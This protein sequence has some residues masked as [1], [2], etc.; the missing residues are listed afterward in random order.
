MHFTKWIGVCSTFLLLL[1]LS[2]TSERANAQVNINQGFEVGTTLP[3]G[4]VGTSWSSTTTLPCT[5]LRSVRANLWSSGQQRNIAPPAWLSNGNDVD[6]SFDYKVINFSAPNAA[7]PPGWGEFRLEY[8]V[9]GGTTYSTY[10]TINDGNHVQS[11]SCATVNQ[12]IPGSLVPS[13]SNV[14]VRFFGQWVTGDY[15]VY[16]D[17]VVIFQEATTPPNCDAALTTP[18][19]ASMSAAINGTLI[20]S[21]ATGSPSGYNVIATQVT[22]GP[23]EIYN[24]NL[25]VVTTTNIGVLQYS[26]AYEI[27]IIPYNQFGNG[28]GCT[29]Y[30]FTTVDPPPPGNVCGIPLTVNGLPFSATDNTGSYGDD[31]STT[32]KPL[33]AVVYPALST[34]TGSGSYLNGDDVVYAYTPQTDQ[35]L[36]ITLTGHGT[37]VG[38]WVFTGCPF[39]TTLAYHTT[40]DALGRAINNLPLSAGETYYIVIS[41]FPTPQSTAYTLNMEEVLF[42]CPELSANIGDACDDGFAT[43]YADTVL[44]DCSCVGTPYDCQDL[45]ANIGSSCDDDNPATFNDLVQEDC[46][47]AGTP[48]QTNDT[49]CDA[50]IIECGDSVSGTTQG[51]TADV[52]GTCGTSDGTAGGVWYV[53]VPTS[54]ANITASL[55]GGGT[56]YDSKIRVF[57]GACDSLVCVGGNDDFCGLQSELNFVASSGTTY[58]ILVHGFSAASGPYTLSVTCDIIYDCPELQANIG[59][60]CDDNDV[61]TGDDTVLEDC[62]CAGTPLPNDAPCLAD[63]ISCGDTVTGTTVGAAGD[64][65]PFC[66]TSNGTG[67]GLWYA[68]TPTAPGLVTASLCGSA[69]DTKLRVFE[70]TCDTLVCVAGNDDACGL[71]SEI[72]FGAVAGTTYYILVHGFSGGQG[73]FNLEVTCVLYDCPEILANIGDACDDGIAGTFGDSIAEDCSCVG[74]PYDCQELLANIGSSCNDENADTFN[75]LVQADCTCAGTPAQTNDTACEAESI[76]CGATVSGTTQGTTADVLGFC[77]TSDGTGGGVWYALDATTNANI[78]ASLCGGGT[79]YDSKIRVFEGSCDALVCVGG[80]DDAC[81][82][83][84]EIAFAASAGTT[85][86]ILVHG[87]NTA[88]GAYSLAVTCATSFDCPEIQA[89]IGDACDDADPT[90][91]N[92]AVQADCSCAGTPIVIDCVADPGCLADVNSAAYA[93]VISLDPFCCNAD[94]DS[95][96]QNA[97]QAQGGL[98]NPAPECAFDCP[99]LLA[100]IGDACDDADPNTENDAVQA[101]CSCAGTPIVV[102]CVADP[103][104][105]ADVNSAAY[106][107][108]IAADPF[109]CDN[110]WDSLC[111]SAYAAEGGLPSQDPACFDCPELLAN[112]GDACDDSNTETVNDMI[113]VNCDC[114]GTPINLFDCPELAANFG[115]ACD[116]GDPLTNG[117]IILEDCTCAGEPVADNSIPCSAAPISCGEDVS[118]NTTGTTPDV[119]P[120]CGTTNGTGGGLWY[121]LTPANGGLVTAT[122]CGLAAFDTKIRVYEGDCEALTCVAGNDD[123]CGLQSSVTFAAVANTSYY[124]LVHGFSAA[125]GAFTMSVTCVLYDCPQLN[126]NIGDLCDDGDPTTFGDSIQEDCSCA[127]TPYDCIDELTNIGDACDDGDPLTF[128]DSIQEDCTCAGTPAQT[129]DTACEAFDISCGD[130]VSGTTEGTT[131]DVVA[132]CGTTNGTGG[133]VWYVFTPSV[134]AN[135]VGSLCGGGTTYDSKIR[136]YSG[137]CDVLACVTGNDDFCGLQSQVS[138]AASAGTTYYIL[139][140]G[141]S[142]AAGSYSLALTCETI[143]DCPVLGANIG[144]ACDDGDENTENDTVGEDCNCAGTPIVTCNVDGGVVM[145]EDQ[146]TGL[147]IGDG[148]ADFIQFT[149]TGNVGAGV[150]GMIEQG[151]Q[152]VVAVSQTGLFN[153]ENLGAGNYQAGYISVEN[154][155]SIAGI[156]NLD[157]LSGC[158]DLSN[159][160]AVKAILLVGGTLTTTSPSLICTG[161]VEVAISGNVGP[162]TR[163]V[164]LNSTATV[165]IDQNTSGSFNFS[166]LSDGTYRI[167]AITYKGGV[168][169]GAIVPPVLPDCVVQSNVLTLIKVTC[170]PSVLESSPNPTQ[171]TSF[172]TFSVPTEDYTTLEVYDMSGRRVAELF[173]QVTEKDAE[174]RLE[175]DGSSLPNGVYVYRLTTANEVVIDKFIMAK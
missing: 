86:Y 167:A 68:L 49:S 22:G 59:D 83:Q 75:D 156:T 107:T 44:E 137:T 14:R 55:C 57:E 136:V 6:I 29:T 9:D 90:T 104:C 100:N 26:T 120:T 60:S 89:N 138:F 12:T 151:T 127:G 155:S 69:F 78:T 161:Q 142:T 95:I 115:D 20:W 73:D 162:N 146:T 91:E 94:W 96:C 92:D 163:F 125:E 82:L 116:D 147:C 34:G 28:Q 11:T 85:Y 81:G 97:Y 21:A 93:I 113:T 45:L 135:V 143:F 129:N 39:S 153:I 25:G 16:L 110:S 133:G 108:V 98:P 71:Q 105:L 118:G 132:T 141:F 58:Y 128:G 114:A 2:I 33:S 152:D 122:T 38:L 15:Y 84:S 166:G 31:Y 47:C 117:D 54:N 24:Q 66:G 41:T 40:S 126:A 36:N 99:E 159:K 140:H 63:A 8:S 157:Q 134:N 30:S 88:S 7:T 67:G 123:A 50:E 102:T 46:S 149:V 148:S 169:L 19:N 174:Y 48:A 76:E 112:I 10:Y 101:D 27:Q 35:G 160:I 119:Q 1:V 168:D 42:D 109:C 131:A 80:N 77:G 130:V 64:N 124:I 170:N 172:V 164:L 3:T 17:N 87:F 171:G 62:T 52:L 111:Q 56:T 175:F 158:Y 13:G 154:L 173:N 65:V 4:W 150:F 106:A 72:T 37:W 103:G 145:T 70:G 51:T 144:D 5:A 53:I 79:N 139:V 165:V 43:T 18:A 121:I 61:T 74:T 23:I 32:D